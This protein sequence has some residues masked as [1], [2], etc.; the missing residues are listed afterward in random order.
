MKSS[1]DI[2]HLF[3]E[4]I[5]VGLG[6]RKRLSENVTEEEWFQLLEIAKKQSLIGIGFAGVQRLGA[7]A[8]KDLQKDSDQEVRPYD[9]LGMSKNL[10]ISWMGIVSK[11]Q[12]RHEVMNRRCERIQKEFAAAGFHC[13]VLKGQGTAQLYDEPLRNLRQCGDIDV[14]VWPKGDWTLTHDQRT[15]QI[16]DYMRSICECRHTTYHNTSVNVFSD[17]EV[18]VHYTPSWLYSPIENRR[19]QRWFAQI[20]PREMEREFSSLEFNLVYILLHIYRHLF[21]EGIG[22]RQVLDYYF[23]LQAAA[24]SGRQ[25]ELLSDTMQ[26]LHRLGG[27]KFAS[28][29][30]FVMQETFGLKEEDMLTAP[31]PKEGAFLLN[32]MLLA[33]NFGKYDKRL[34]GKHSGGLFAKF[35]MHVMRNIKFLSHYPNE[36]IWCPFWKIWHQLWLKRIK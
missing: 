24:H 30:M 33:G 13:C 17:V 1:E 2:N 9:V 19:L 5:Q 8:A 11:I 4:L 3:F 6:S 28:A 7:E 27:S 36:V 18:E 23:V 26:T 29:L 22:L 25:R 14:W 15:R 35:S 16:L 20:A 31:D 32:E 34:E 12:R 10:Y 21:G